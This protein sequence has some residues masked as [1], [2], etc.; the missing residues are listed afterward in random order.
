M[1]FV[2]MTT[3]L[4]E[5]ISGTAPRTSTADTT[6][7]SA[8]RDEYN[9]RVPP[10]GND[11]DDCDIIYNILLAASRQQHKTHCPTRTHSTFPHVS[12][13]L[14]R[15]QS[16]HHSSDLRRKPSEGEV[17]AP[18]WTAIKWQTQKNLHTACLAEQWAGT[19]GPAY[20]GQ[21]PSTSPQEPRTQSHC[22]GRHGPRR[23]PSEQSPVMHD[24]C[25]DEGEEFGDGTREAKTERDAEKKN[26]DTEMKPPAKRK[27]PQQKKKKTTPPKTIGPPT[28]KK[29]LDPPQQKKNPHPP[30]KF[31]P[32]H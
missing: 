7:E 27:D 29:I 6:S 14:W 28:E 8:Q 24:R 16:G 5:Q 30:R 20:H 11:G 2:V 25:C 15:G 1:A 10:R 17:L 18:I 13:P 9:Y 3:E 32:F 22:S 23:S 19:A 31:N 4:A 21:P 26:R 12:R